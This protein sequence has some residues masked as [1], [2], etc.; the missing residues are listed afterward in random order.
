MCVDALI[1]TGKKKQK[2]KMHATDRGLDNSYR[3]VCSFLEKNHL[4][5]VIRAH[6]AQ[7]NG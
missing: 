6:E 4:L 2:D 3:A 7:A 1:S 5:S